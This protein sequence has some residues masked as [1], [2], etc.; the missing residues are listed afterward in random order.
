MRYKKYKLNCG[1]LGNL[2]WWNNNGMIA[3]RGT[4]RSCRDCG[5]KGSGEWTATVYIIDEYE[6]AKGEIDV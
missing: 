4:N 6:D 1:H 3:V 2:I 5:K